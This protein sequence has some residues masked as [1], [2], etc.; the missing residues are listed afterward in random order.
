[1]MYSLLWLPLHFLWVIWEDEF[2]KEWGHQQP[3]FA[4]NTQNTQNNLPACS[5]LI[6]GN[7][8]S[9]AVI[10]YIQLCS[11]VNI[12]T[13][14]YGPSSHYT[15]VFNAHK[16][17]CT[18]LLHLFTLMWSWLAHWSQLLVTMWFDFTSTT[19]SRLQVVLGFM[20]SDQ[21][22]WPEHSIYHNVQLNAKA[23]FG[24]SYSAVPRLLG[25]RYLPDTDIGWS[26]NLPWKPGG[27]SICS[28]FYI[29]SGHYGE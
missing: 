17:S 21:A 1:M 12:I 20:Q 11:T 25:C 18:I 24:F 26:C 23:G 13:T 15:V 22:A 10:G 14:T 19:R 28:L 8:I 4:Q 7:A 3:V 27:S 2:F 16:M 5:T 9:S 29:S 6:S